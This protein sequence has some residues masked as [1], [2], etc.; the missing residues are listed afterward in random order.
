VAR[1]LWPGLDP[2]GQQVRTADSTEPWREVVGVARDA[3]YLFL[4]ESPLGAY[5]MPLP[6]PSGGTFVIRTTGNPR[7]ALASLTDIARELDSDLPIATA[8]TMEERIRRS[9]RLRRAV[10]SLLGVLGAL[11]LLLTSVGIYGVAAHSASMRTREVGIRISLGARAS[12]VLRM[13]VRENLSLSLVGV[14]IG[15]GLSAAGATMLTSFLFGVTAVDPA[16]FSGGA[17][18]LCL[19][20]L[21]ASY[22]PARRAARLEPLVALR[23][24]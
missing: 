10:V 21:L 9:V 16:T 1:S 7:A 5:Y 17:L 23:R 18:A 3:K 24:E 20:S 8:Q 12:D 2:L 22:L 4:T 15:L 14:A 19:V 11:T 6:P 13:I